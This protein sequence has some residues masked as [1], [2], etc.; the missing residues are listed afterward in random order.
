MVRRYVLNDKSNKIQ[1]TV[2]AHAEH[3]VYSLSN[4]TQD[5]RKVYTYFI[6]FISQ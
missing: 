5:T 3:E 4:D 2:K 1:F 6:L